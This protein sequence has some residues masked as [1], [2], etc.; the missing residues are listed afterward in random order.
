MASVVLAASDQSVRGLLDLVLRLD[1]HEV[2]VVTDRRALQQVVAATH[3]QPVVLVLGGRLVAWNE[4]ALA[5]TVRETKLGSPGRAGILLA[6]SPET[7]TPAARYLLWSCHT[8]LVPLPFDLA[9]LRT[10]IAHA[11][12]RAGVVEAS[13]SVPPPSPTPPGW[14]A[15]DALPYDPPLLGVIGVREGSPQ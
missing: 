7:L 6:A 3:P 14:A 11:A 12:H 2:S 10:T 8:A 9:R 5:A 15:L 13:P 1:G 4:E